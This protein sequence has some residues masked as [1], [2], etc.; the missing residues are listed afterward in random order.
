M[1]TVRGKIEN[2]KVLALEL[3]D[4]EFEGREVT[5]V[6]EERAGELR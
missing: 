6:L 5:I 1:I 2:G 3:I 4:E